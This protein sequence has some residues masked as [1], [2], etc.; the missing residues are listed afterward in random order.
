MSC[1]Q[2]L[3]TTDTE[4]TS[5]SFHPPPCTSSLFPPLTSPSLYCWATDTEQTTLPPPPPFTLHHVPPPSFL[6]SP[7]PPSTARQQTLN[8]LHYHLPLLSSSTMYLLPLLLGYNYIMNTCIKKDHKVLH[9]CFR[10]SDFVLYMV[11]V[12][13]RSAYEPRP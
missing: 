7:L 1:S 4:Q 8:K 13:L 12:Y 6:H 10:I 5:P 3:V 2:L 11:H 9:I